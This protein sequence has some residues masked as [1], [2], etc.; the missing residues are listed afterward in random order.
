MPPCGYSVICVLESNRMLFPLPRILGGFR[1][2][3]ALIFP[4]EN[5]IQNFDYAGRHPSDR[6]AKPDQLWRVRDV[7][8]EYVEIKLTDRNES[9]Q[10]DDHRTH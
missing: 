5:K 8:G 9:D 6:I 2:F 3:C 7:S 1:L 10:H 4:S